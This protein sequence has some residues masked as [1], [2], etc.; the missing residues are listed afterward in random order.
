MRKDVR[1]YI[2]TNVVV[3][4]GVENDLDQVGLKGLPGIRY[5]QT[6]AFG[7]LKQSNKHNA[8]DDAVQHMKLAVS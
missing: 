3:A 2:G 4:H 1:Q 7:A 5:A 8:V 6:G